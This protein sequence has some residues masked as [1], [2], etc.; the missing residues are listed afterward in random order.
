MLGA[1]V[2]LSVEFLAV[3]VDVLR[4]QEVR[5]CTPMYEVQQVGVKLII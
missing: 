4:L 5:D 2:G 3:R 1:S